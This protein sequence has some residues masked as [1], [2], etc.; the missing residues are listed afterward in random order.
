M[1][2]QL[3]RLFQQI[4]FVFCSFFG[5]NELFLTHKPSLH[6]K[7]DGVVFKTFSSEFERLDPQSRLTKELKLSTPHIKAEW[8]YYRVDMID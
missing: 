3:Y 4:L 5:K 6:N 1:S 7:L 8:R 2:S